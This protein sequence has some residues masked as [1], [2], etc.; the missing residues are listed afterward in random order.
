MING[1]LLNPLKTLELISKIPKIEEDPQELENLFKK[2]I[3]NDPI[4]NELKLL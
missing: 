3:E 1:D 4:L 2:T